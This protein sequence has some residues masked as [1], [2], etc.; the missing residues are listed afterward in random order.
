MSDNKKREIR[1]PKRESLV[2]ALDVFDVFREA[3]KLQLDLGYWMTITFPSKHHLN[4][5]LSAQYIDPDLMHEVY[6]E[7][8]TRRIQE[9][10]P[11]CKSYSAFLRSDNVEKNKK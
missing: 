10:I 11:L 8:L 4:K 7:G 1:W 6:G 5:I 2:D 3:C 9:T